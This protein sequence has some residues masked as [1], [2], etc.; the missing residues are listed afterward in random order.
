MALG[1]GAFQYLRGI[2]QTQVAVGVQASRVLGEKANIAMPANGASIV[3]VD[4]LGTL[5]TAG[6]TTSRPIA[7]VTKMM[8]AYVILKNLPL[9]P[10]EQG[11][12]IPITARDNQRYFQAIS[13][14]ESAL[15]VI[16]GVDLTQYQLL[17][18]ARLPSSRR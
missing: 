6:Q 3:A 11:P 2:P 16:A 5:A 17:Q 14:D 15:G 8:T 10:G 7:S 9:S 12:K 4:G 1:A 13:N 18:G